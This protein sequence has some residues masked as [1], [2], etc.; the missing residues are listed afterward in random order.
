MIA[1]SGTYKIHKTEAKFGTLPK[2]VKPTCGSAV[3]SSYLSVVNPT[4]EAE[5][6]AK[7]ADPDKLPTLCKKCFDA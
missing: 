5:W 7:A 6:M 1:K 3:R 4:N 2:H